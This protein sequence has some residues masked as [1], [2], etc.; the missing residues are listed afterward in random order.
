MLHTLPTGLAALI[1]SFSFASAIPVPRRPVPHHTHL[2]RHPKAH[3]LMPIMPLTLAAPAALLPAVATSSHLPSTSP[4]ATPSPPPTA[5]PVRPSSRPLSSSPVTAPRPVPTAPSPGSA[6]AVSPTL[7][8]P[9]Q[10]TAYATRFVTIT[11]TTTAPVV[12]IQTVVQTATITATPAGP[13]GAAPTAAPGATWSL[14][15]AFGNDL[16]AELGVKTW[17]W[18]QTNVQV[19]QGI[20]ETAWARATPPPAPAASGAP[21]APGA[22]ALVRPMRDFSNATVMQV[23]YPDG[24]INPANKV[25]PVGG[26]GMYLTPRASPSRFESSN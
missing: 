1:V 2:T 14:T 11:A 24:S 15:S 19:L 8:P 20:P 18:G 22:K 26:T 16:P 13:V 3:V 10:A 7:P 9:A 21:P 4:S 12:E 23:L 6:P 25:A 5:A 17:E